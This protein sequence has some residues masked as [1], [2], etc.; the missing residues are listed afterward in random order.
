MGRGAEG[1]YRVEAGANGDV[2]G[3]DRVLPRAAGA[4]QVSEAGGVRGV[5]ADGDWEGEEERDEG[6]SGCWVLGDGRWQ[7]LRPFARRRP[8]PRTQDPE[9][10]LLKDRCE[11]GTGQ[12]CCGAT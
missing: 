3:T 11:P 10:L 1:V 4:F 7:T 2:R 12:N 5:A 8:G 6:K 9:P